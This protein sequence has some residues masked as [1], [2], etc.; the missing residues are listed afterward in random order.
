LVIERLIANDA[1]GAQ[2]KL[3]DVN[4]LVTVGGRERSIEEHGDLL[5]RAGFAISRT[6]PTMSPLTIIEAIPGPD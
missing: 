5:G 1:R 3:F 2:A 4:M 6:I